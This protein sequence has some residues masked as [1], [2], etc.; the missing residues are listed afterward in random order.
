MS[1]SVALRW[2][3]GL[4]RGVVSGSEQIVWLSAFNSFICTLRFLLVFPV[5]WQ[6]G[7]TPTV[8]FSY[9]LFVALF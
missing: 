7:A 2:M 4:N 6:F 8:F 3:S 9:Q 5:L 1:V